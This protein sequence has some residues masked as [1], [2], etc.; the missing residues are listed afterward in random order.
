MINNFDISESKWM[1]MASH[2][3]TGENEL[4]HIA[5]IIVK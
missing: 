5:L 3:E 2:N 1:A 4:G